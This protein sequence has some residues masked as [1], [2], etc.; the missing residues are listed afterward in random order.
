MAVTRQGSW[1]AFGPRQVEVN[2]NGA[3]EAVSAVL[4]WRLNLGETWPQALTWAAAAGS[5]T[6]LTRGTGEC[7]PKDVM[8][9]LPDIRVIAL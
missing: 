9:L 4:P 6:V 3:G 1:R 8:R 7:R 5:A 2:G